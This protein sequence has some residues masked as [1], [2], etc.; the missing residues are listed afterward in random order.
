MFQAPVDDSRWEAAGFGR[1]G[2]GHQQPSGLGRECRLGVGTMVATVGRHKF[3][4]GGRE[5]VCCSPLPLSGRFV[6]VMV[7]FAAVRLRPLWSLAAA[8]AAVR[9]TR[10]VPSSPHCCCLLAAPSYHTAHG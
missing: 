7:P 10:P 5:C 6:M 1:D 4:G 2:R 9:E 8:V 3:G